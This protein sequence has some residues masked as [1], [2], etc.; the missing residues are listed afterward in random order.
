[1]NN[2]DNDDTAE[3]PEDM[4]LPAVAGEFDDATSTGADADAPAV[5]ALA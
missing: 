4:P 3:H 2:A 1:M 5:L